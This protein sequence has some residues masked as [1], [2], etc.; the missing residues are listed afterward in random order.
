M[1]EY[2][3][4]YT[5]S[6]IDARLGEIDNVVKHT[7]QDLTEEQKAEKI[8]SVKAIYAELGLEEEAKQEIIRLHNQAISYISQLEVDPEKA[9]LLENYAKKLIGR[10][11]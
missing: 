7:Q 4:S 3:L 9:A 6:D 5:A 11:K 8:A 10:A 1:A 2:K